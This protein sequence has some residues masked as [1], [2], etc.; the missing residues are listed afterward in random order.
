[1]KTPERPEYV[2]PKEEGA[3]R[4]MDAFRRLAKKIVKVSRE[5]IVREES[6]EREQ[7]KKSE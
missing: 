1:M 4:P 6:K 2:G 3:A 7:K 5:E